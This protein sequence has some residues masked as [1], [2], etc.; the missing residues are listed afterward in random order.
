MTVTP[1]PFAARP[2]A[3]E[4]DP[5]ATPAP[6][7]GW[8]E[9]LLDRLITGV[10]AGDDQAELAYRVGRSPGTVTNRLR[11][12]LPL[13]EQG[14]PADRV[15]PRMRDHLADD[16]YD[17]RSAMLRT[18]PPIPIVRNEI[19][20]LPGLTQHH[21]LTFTRAVFNS[22]LADPHLLDEL[23][24]ECRRR[25]LEQRA[26]AALADSLRTGQINAPEPSVIRMAQAWWDGTV[27]YLGRTAGFAP[28]SLD[29]DW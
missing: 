3:V 12:M 27:R 17:W 23:R 7:R 29:P 10:R 26:L 1:L 18:P 25:G 15:L 16:A 28:H 20:G 2:A 5:A 14:C 6:P 11:R 8:T 19:Q 4:P 21:L 22:P 13:D 9:E 24:E